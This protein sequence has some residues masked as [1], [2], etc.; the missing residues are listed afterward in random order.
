MQNPQIQP[1]KPSTM[2]TM[3]PLGQL[4]TVQ[5]VSL[6]T[7]DPASFELALR[8]WELQCSPIAKGKFEHSI[9]LLMTPQWSVY[10]EEFNLAAHV[11]GLTPAG[12]LVLAIPLGTGIDARYWHKSHSGST[13]PSTLPGPLDVQI[14]QG[15]SQLVIMVDID[16]C[17][18]HLDEQLVDVLLK[19]SAA[20]K[21]P[22]RHH[23]LCHL[24][25]WGK[26]TLD[27]AQSDPVRVRDTV[28][29]DAMTQEL[30][31]YLSSI[32]AELEPPSVNVASSARQNGL[33]RALE[34][35]RHNRATT[36]VSVSELLELANISERSLQYAFREAFDMSPAEYMKRR[37]LHFAR[38]RL[39]S[40]CPKEASVSKV[41][42]DLGFYELGRFAND[43]RQVFG[44]FPSQTLRNY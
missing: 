17:R 25:S 28:V 31:H 36:R 2:E 13:L 8:P 6:T 20:H 14:P 29:V 22:I 33:R 5:T 43:Y 7:N 40:A 11:Q 27:L 30:L 12:K 10:R 26:R 44:Q 21:L 15:H 1:N 19:V 9:T 35:L 24:V 38:Q 39:L 42:T 18:R 32:A 41:A 37:R 4:N 23:V 3:A 16:H 34:H